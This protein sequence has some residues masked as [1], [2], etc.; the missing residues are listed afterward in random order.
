M[1]V[2]EIPLSHVKAV[3]F[4]FGGAVDAY[5]KELQAHRFTTGEAAPSPPHGL[6]ELV[7]ARV[8]TPGKP[9]DFVANYRIVDDTPPP[10]SLA[11]RKAAL[12]VSAQQQADA[13][14]AKVS[15]PL[16]RRLAMLRV[17]EA[18]NVPK[19]KMTAAHVA[20]LKAATDRSAKEAAIMLNLA[21]MESDID[22][23]T[24]ATID[25]WKPTPFPT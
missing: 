6:V 1:D 9:D 8:Q 24:S 17:H 20:T 3:G 18:A 7:V 21:Q 5:I 22:D 15:P 11:D 25:A 13:A 14:L 16:K 23:L 4:E 12:A 2:V 19:D 10:P